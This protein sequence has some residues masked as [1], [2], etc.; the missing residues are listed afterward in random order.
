MIYQE[1]L[2]Q[3]IHFRQIKGIFEIDYSLKQGR[4]WNDEIG[5]LSEDY[6]GHC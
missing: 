6:H 4:G 2:Q 5:K 1:Q 3:L